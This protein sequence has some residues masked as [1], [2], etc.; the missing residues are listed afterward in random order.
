VITYVDTSTLIKLLIDEVG[1]AEAAAIWDEPDV[2]ATVRVAHVEARA[3]L[4]AAQ[5][6]RRITLAVFRSATTGL[7]MLWSQ[8]SVVEIDED[9]M[10]LAGDLATTHGLRG[11]DAAHLAAAHLVGADVFSSADRRLCEAASSSGF[12]VANPLEAASSETETES[13]I[14]FA[15]D[16]ATSN[17]KDSGVLGIPVP[18]T[19]QRLDDSRDGFRIS[20]YTIQELTAGY[21]DWMSTDGWIFDAQYSQLDPYLSEERPHIGYITQSI[22]VK[23]TDP[24]TT[25]AVIIGN[26]DGKPGNKRDLR[27]YLTQTPD[28]ELPRRS[29]ELRWADDSS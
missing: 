21:K 15:G 16:P 8:L 17:T 22:Y 4:A 3:A 29:I 27:V 13:T 9:L 5:R 20:G 24:P 28:D 14:E 11:Y 26:F 25:I 19:A 2:L 7:E 18:T 1:T 23:P 10:R 12:Y 6:Q